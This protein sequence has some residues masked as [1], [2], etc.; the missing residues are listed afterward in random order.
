MIGQAPD[1][2][3]N[4]DAS[5]TTIGSTSGMAGIEAQVKPTTMVFGYYG[6][7]RIDQEVASDAG[8]PIGYGVPGAASANRA[9]D[10][11]TAGFN[12]AFFRE[13][14]YG[15][16]Q[17]ITQYSYVKR[18]P[19]SVPDGTPTSARVHIVYVNFRYVLP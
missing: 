13:P 17:L 18:T 6:T 4:A 14:R 8:K 15:A 11:T 19:W 16:M 2:I 7:V 1:F 5:V 9:I 12:H 10:E 3:V